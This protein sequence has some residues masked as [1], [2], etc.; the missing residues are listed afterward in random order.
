MNKL[1]QAWLFV[2]NRWSSF[3]FTIGSIG[4]GFYHFFHPNILLNS[5]AY[6]PM[7]YITGLIG[8]KHLGLLFIILGFIKLY[9]III[10]NTQIKVRLYFALLFMW[11]ALSIG[12]LFSF[13]QG[14]DNAA[15]IYT[16]IIASLSTNILSSKQAINGR[17]I[18]E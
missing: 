5:G 2:W 8:G 11:I 9:G 16:S 4:Y 1:R 3:T 13:V 18:N 14:Y 7:N 12:F 10:D 6:Q 17:G 15:W